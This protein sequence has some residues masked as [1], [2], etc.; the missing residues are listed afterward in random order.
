M[1]GWRQR[2]LNKLSRPETSAV[3]LPRSKDGRASYTEVHLNLT[4][5]D[6]EGRNDMEITWE[7]SREFLVLLA[8]GLI[9]SSL[10]LACG[11]VDGHGV[12]NLCA[13]SDLS[14]Q[15]TILRFLFELV[16]TQHVLTLVPHWS[17]STLFQEVTRAQWLWTVMLLS[18]RFSDILTSNLL[19]VF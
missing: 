14:D 18:A 4:R 16:I 3:L 2:T 9:V 11:K 6:R 19:T 10:R 7:R 13:C 8:A 5:R 15:D 12:C 1:Q 17:R